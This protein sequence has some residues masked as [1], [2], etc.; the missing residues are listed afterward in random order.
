MRRGTK[1][2]M[3]TNSHHYILSS[4]IFQ[5]TSPVKMTIREG[6]EGRAYDRRTTSGQLQRRSEEVCS[7][8]SSE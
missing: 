7:S 2:S 3:Q 5:S 6:V 4:Y 1:R 8:P